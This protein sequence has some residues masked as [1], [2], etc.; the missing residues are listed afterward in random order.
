[1][2]LSPEEADNVLVWKIMKHGGMC[3]SDEEQMGGVGGG[4]RGAN[5]E[6]L[7]SDRKCKK[8]PV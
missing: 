8:A 6:G 4:G 5:T 7:L 2:Q 3:S 1:M